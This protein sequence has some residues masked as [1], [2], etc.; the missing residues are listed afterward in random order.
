MAIADLLAKLVELKS[1][2]VANLNSMGV[3]ADESEKLNTL[4][5]KVLKCKTDVIWLQDTVSTEVT[6]VNIPN[7][8]TSIGDSAFNSCSRLSSITIPDSVTSIGYEVFD[9]TALLANQTGVKYAD[10]W[11]VDCDTDITSVDIKNG[12]RGIA[13]EAFFG[14]KSLTSITIPNSVTSIGDSAFH[15]CTSLVSITIPDSVTSIG[16][17]AFR[18][19]KSLTSITIPDNVMYIE[20]DVF[21]NCTSLE[22]VTIGNGVISIWKYAF[23]SCTRLTGIYVSK[24]NN[25]YCDINGVLF[26]KNKSE[27]LAYPMGKIDNEYSIPNGVTSIG[28]SIFSGCTNLTSITIPDSVTTIGDCTFQSCSGLTSVTIGNG[29]TSIGDMAFAFCTSLANIY[30]KGTEEQWNAISK[31]QNWNQNMGSNVEGGTVITYNYTG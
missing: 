11:V 28:N 21:T 30:Y 27:L 24:N 4:V 22:S 10:T 19:C 23:M 26:N 15:D 8:V 17:S 16:D 31:S 14:C 12:T 18:T 7:G 20:A 6:S 9:G 29:V 13:N 1:Q 2:L 5:P 3:T 25:N